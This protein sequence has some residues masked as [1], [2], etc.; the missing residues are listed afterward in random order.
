MEEDFER[1]ELLQSELIRYLK[2]F[3]ADAGASICEAKNDGIDSMHVPFRYSG[4]SLGLTVLLVGMVP[5]RWLISITGE[6]INDPPGDQDVSWLLPVIES[7]VAQIC[8]NPVRWYVSLE[9]VPMA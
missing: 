4:V 6:T 8:E 9:D 1:V 5:S 3:L 2:Q 7:A